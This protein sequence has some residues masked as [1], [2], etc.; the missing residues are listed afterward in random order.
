LFLLI[1][2]AACAVPEPDTIAAA[3]VSSTHEGSV[4]VSSLADLTKLSEI[5]MI[6]GDLTITDT[7]LETL[8]GLGHLTEV[9]GFLVVADN[10]QLASIKGLKS[11]SIVGRNLVIESNQSLSSLE[12]LNALSSVGGLRVAY[13]TDLTDLDGLS[14][15]SSIGWTLDISGNYSLKSI[16]G[17]AQVTTVPGPLFIDSNR[18]LASIE[19]LGAISHAGGVQV[20]G[21]SELTDLEGLRGLKTIGRELVLDDNDK[22][23]NSKPLDQVQRLGGLSNNEPKPATPVVQGG[24]YPDRW[25]EEATRRAGRNVCLGLVYADGCKK[26]RTGVVVVEVTLN[27][28]GRVGGLK[29]VSNS[30]TTEPKVVWDCLEKTLLENWVFHPPQGSTNV[31]ELSFTFSDKC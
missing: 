22:L 30:I 26:T 25:V 23:V 16:A 9:G 15:L 19:G 28:K 17:L 21:M 1:I 18:N 3:K 14:S 7:S 29:E 24:P 6:T 5:T 11:L 2:A 31:L 12:G 27:D 10:R 20:S 13:N 8:E 4:Q